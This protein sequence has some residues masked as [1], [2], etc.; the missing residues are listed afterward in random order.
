M[1]GGMKWLSTLL[2]AFVC[3]L[4]PASG[5]GA[6]DTFPSTTT[7]LGNQITRWDQTFDLQ[8][9]GSV[10]VTLEI[11]FD[12]GNDPGHGPYFL[13]PTRQGYDGT[14]NRVYDIRDVEA[15][16]STGAPAKVYLTRGDYWLEVRVGDE[17]IG[18]VSGVQT[19]TLT[20]TIGQVM[21][22][23]DDAVPPGES[24]AIEAD[25]FYWNAIGDRWVIPIS[26]VLITVTSPVDA[27]ASQ[28]F[29]GATGAATSCDSASHEGAR[30]S[31][32]HRS[33]TPGEPLTI[34]VLY[35]SGS[36]NTTPELELASDV[37]RAFRPA[38]GWG[39]AGLVI[40]VVGGAAIGRALW[41]ATRDEYYV[42]LT[43]GLTPT[44]AEA[45]AT[46]TMRHGPAV[47]V[48]FDPPKGVRPGLIG[49]LWD[50]K[51]DAEDVAATVV[52]LAVRGYLRIEAVATADYRLVKLKNSDS[53]MLKYEGMLFDGIFEG[54]DSVR[55]STLRTTFASTMQAVCVQM[56]E[57]TV[58]SGWY[59][60]S[61]AASRLSW[62]CLGTGLA[63]VGFFGSFFVASIGGSVIATIPLILLGTVLIATHRAAPA[64]K[65]E[66]SRVL[67]ESK[68]FELFL[69]TAEANQLRLNE[70]EDIFSRYLPYAIAFGITEEWT[71]KFKNF[72]DQGYPVRDPDWMVGFTTGSFW[73][74][75]TGLTRSIADF[76][77]QAASAMAAP[78]PG[79]S[80]SSGF[81]G[82]GGGGG[83]FS[84][85]GGGGGGGG[86][87]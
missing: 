81:S 82:G 80:G 32:A 11:D 14:Y 27:I 18:N 72:A 6:D 22:G 52:D 7:T 68:G 66:G 35:P 3:L 56:Y 31:F 71:K 75:G 73:S 10:K 34:D 61:P 65:A 87:W 60:K 41:R 19:Y 79:S 63:V 55:L 13:F 53:M 39:I 54:R 67:A 57:D 51:A 43:P 78:T 59:A 40:L 12:F 21:N 20:Y 1:M 4:L 58:R 42:G 38:P 5:A 30:A 47:A 83:G 50:E 25:E 84:G 48:R 28:C 64:R 46:R 29:A 69:R 24:E 85:G 8:P 2:L 15:S 37:A 77:S 62:G 9:D 45:S 26:N 17:N 33:L 49:T 44:F 16:S 36:F 86:G 70:K 23:V 76:T 74:A